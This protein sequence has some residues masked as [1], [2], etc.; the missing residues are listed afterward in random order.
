MKIG[1]LLAA[2]I[3]SGCGDA[4]Q[5]APARQ[6]EA[7]KPIATPSCTQPKLDFRASGLDAA[8]Q[9]LFSERFGAAVERACRDGLFAEGPLIDQRS[10]DRSTLFVMNAPEAN[11]TSIYFGPSA[12]PPAMLLEAPFGLPPQI[13]S[14]D[15]LHEAIYCAVR[16]ATPQEEEESGRC[17][18][19]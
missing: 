8:A 1:L 2:L 9:A 11:V 5:A 7:V 10:V 14:A 15:D 4:P 16:G 18:P 17:L 13:P 3:L 6:V 19:D 12:A